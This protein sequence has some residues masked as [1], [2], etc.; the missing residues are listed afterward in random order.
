[1]KKVFIFVDELPPALGGSGNVSYNL[2]N[3]FE[4]EFD[5]HLSSF[6]T[7]LNT[8]TYAHFSGTLYPI[9]HALWKNF[10][11]IQ[12]TFLFLKCFLKYGKKQTWLFGSWNHTRPLI[13]LNRWFKW[14]YFVY[15]HGT[16]IS[17]LEERGRVEKCLKSLENCEK[18]ISVSGY[19]KRVL[20]RLGFPEEKICVLENGTNHNVYYPITQFSARSELNITASLVLMSACRFH[21]IK[22]IPLALATV[23]E[24]VNRGITDLVYI[25]LGTG[26]EAEVTELKSI[27]KSYNIERYV[28]FK[29]FVHPVNDTINSSTLLNA[30]YNCADVFL[31]LN[32]VQEDGSEDACPLNI[33]EAGATGAIVIAG[34]N[35]GLP[36]AITHGNNGFLVD[37][38]SEAVVVNTVANYIEKIYTDQQLKKNLSDASINYFGH[39]KSWEN[40]YKA[41]KQIM[42]LI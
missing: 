33:R 22:G 18:V 10:R 4:K 17:R 29:G 41:L 27:I 28:Q 14:N 12:L 2:I 26:T 15:A 16:D 1:M 23:K 7:Y 13:F 21:P 38:E 31:N 39:K 8:K 19:L 42:N 20:V 36:E 24:L 3:Y 6:D 9:K 25:L 37:T 30:Y 11:D 35:G 5:V 40:Q 34:N 32:R